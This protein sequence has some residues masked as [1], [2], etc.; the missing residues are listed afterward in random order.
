MIGVCLVGFSINSKP[1][2]TSTNLIGNKDN[3]TGDKK[4]EEVREKMTNSSQKLKIEK[5]SSGM[6]PLQ[7]K[8]GQR[9]NDMTLKP[10]QEVNV[11]KL[12]SSAYMNKTAAKQGQ[13][14]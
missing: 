8:V 3:S 9:F 12:C 14:H 13:Q 7:I 6:S 4:K 5:R 11:M 10:K 1:R 2:P